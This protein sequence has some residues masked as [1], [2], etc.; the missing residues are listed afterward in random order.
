MPAKKT[1]KGRTQKPRTTKNT[2][3]AIVPAQIH[4]GPYPT[5]ASQMQDF[6]RLFR[7]LNSRF[8]TMFSM[9]PFSNLTPMDNMFPAKLADMRPAFSD[10]V[11]RGD[12]YVIHSELPGVKKED[13]RITTH[14]GHVEISAETSSNTS[15]EGG[16]GAVYRERSQGSFFRAFRLS[17]EVDADKAEAQFENGVLI[18]TLPKKNPTT[19]QPRTVPVK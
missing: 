7:A 1:K 14:G 16:K 10:I 12:A 2:E 18:L 3:T 17:D 15:S 4:E 13:V 6:D 8:A 19:G 5:L 11:D 9:E